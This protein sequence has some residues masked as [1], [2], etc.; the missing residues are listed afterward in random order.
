[1]IHTQLSHSFRLYYSVREL[2]FAQSCLPAYILNS[3]VI[4]CNAC[5]AYVPLRST[6]VAARVGDLRRSVDAPNRADLF[7][8]VLVSLRSKTDTNRRNV[9]VDCRI[10][11]RHVGN[12]PAIVIVGAGYGH[13]R[14]SPAL[15]LCVV[16]PDFVAVMDGFFQGGFSV[17]ANIIC[18]FFVRWIL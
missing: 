12:V 4:H 1:M 5:A 3:H 10:A 15:F 2:T 16:D 13:V 14:V 6:V 8:Y 7:D 17:G 11:R 18:R 9:T